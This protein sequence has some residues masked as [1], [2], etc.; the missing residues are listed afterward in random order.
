MKG[1]SIQSI[2]MVLLLVLGATA[3]QAGAAVFTVG[4]NGEGNYT[5]IQEAV[6]NAQN[7]DT[8]LVSPGVYR[9]NVNVNK[10]LS[11]ISST[12]L[13]GDT[14]NRT[15]V[16]GAIPANDVFSIRSNNVR[17]SGFHIVGGP[18]GMDTYQEAGLYLEGVQNCSLSN[19]T[20]VLNDVGIGLNNSQR[21]IFDSNV[22]G[23]G[24]SGIFL[25]RSNENLLS[26]NFVVTNSKGI[27]MDNSTNNTLMN[28]TVDSNEIGLFLGTSRMNMLEYN[29]ISRNSNGVILA[30]M[31][32]SNVL[33][34]NSLYMNGLGM[35][36]NGSSGNTIYLN[37]F[38]NFLNAE[39]EGTNIWNSSSAGNTWS[40]YNG[41][42]TDGNGIGDTPY[43]VNQTTGSIDYMPLVE[44]VSTGDTQNESDNTSSGTP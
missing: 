40:D 8:I 36:L 38:F 21:N 9:E 25:S 30:N 32:E 1:K 17:I 29:F 31:A 27:W 42:D 44:N 20:L 26:N 14:L 15:Y 6:N 16:I 24:T 7:G 23:L 3:T 13:S 2:C 10:E 41:T 18:S 12:D 33:A 34:N 11:I 22:I 4:G 39:D 28:N 19:N 43:V 35:Y 37:S 5:S